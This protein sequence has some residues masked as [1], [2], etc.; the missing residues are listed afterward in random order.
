[1]ILNIALIPLGKHHNVRRFFK[2]LSDQGLGMLCFRKT[3]IQKSISCG[4]MH[5]HLP[6][7][8][9]FGRH[10]GRRISMVVI[11]FCLLSWKKKIACSLFDAWW[12]FWS[13]IVSYLW[14]SKTTKLTT[15]KLRILPMKRQW[16]V[17]TQNSKGI[18]EEA[19]CTTIANRLTHLSRLSRISSN[20]KKT[21][22]LKKERWIWEEVVPCLHSPLFR[23]LFLLLARDKKKKMHRH[24]VRYNF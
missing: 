22:S 8:I 13:G 18:G 11:H 17:C 24:Y 16:N 15:R 7:I 9:S 23:I 1:M 14:Y 12:T 10:P 5:P 2:E 20:A 6:S 21:P 3:T 19:F 4:S